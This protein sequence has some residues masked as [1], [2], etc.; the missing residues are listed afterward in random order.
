MPTT[1]TLT[2]SEQKRVLDHAIKLLRADKKLGRLSA[3]RTA[4]AELVN[5]P[6]KK[7][8]SLSSEP[9][10]VFPQDILDER[11]DV[12]ARSAKAKAGRPPG[13][14]RL[15][16]DEQD[17]VAKAAA[18]AM[19]L[20]R[21]KYNSEAFAE[22][23]KTL[24]P[25]RR[26]VNVNGKSG[27]LWF[28]TKLEKELQLI[29][30]T[31]ARKQ[32]EEEKAK[33][34]EYEENAAALQRAAE[35]PEY[36][37]VSAPVIPNP[38]IPNGVDH[39]APEAPST[40]VVAE[41][42]SQPTPDPEPIAD[43]APVALAFFSGG[44]RQHL[45]DF[46]AGVILDAT[47]K[48]VAE[49]PSILRGAIPAPAQ[50]QITHAAAP[51]AVATPAP[52]AVHYAS[53]EEEDDGEG[54]EEEIIPP[55]I[56]HENRPAVAPPPSNPLQ[57]R[58]TRVL[59]I[60]VQG[61]QREIL[62]QRY[63]HRLDLH[64]MDSDE[65]VGALKRAAAGP[66]VVLAW[67]NFTSIAKRQAV[68]ER[69]QRFYVVNGGMSTLNERLDYISTTPLSKLSTSKRLPGSDQFGGRATSVSH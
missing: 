2:S 48:V 42:A 13:T 65:S 43:V 17:A 63:G 47:R 29:K 33:Q 56:S 55:Y 10:I 16:L 20:Q 37:S 24:P 52:A 40:P 25:E 18:L 27:Q 26:V 51:A 64:T 39:D 66:D 35:N 62:K 3:I 12:I 31:E 28:K 9:W 60:G 46:I 57:L 36:A 22:G 19:Y 21:L 53:A 49:V 1:N 34:A 45:V 32:K 50:R 7:I 67:G 38:I 44:L 54:H 30:R 58:L 6:I 68:E 23:Q 11:Q 59:V 41:P 61:Q 14:V 15:T 8:S 4:V 5:R 69:A